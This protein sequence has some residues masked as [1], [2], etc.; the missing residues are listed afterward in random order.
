[1]KEAKVKLPSSGAEIKKEAGTDDTKGK[2]TILKKVDTT[3]QSPPGVTS[4]ASPTLTKSVF[5]D[6]IVPLYEID[7]C[8]IFGGA[9]DGKSRVAKQIAEE[10][11]ERKK[12]VLYVDTERG[13]LKR[14]LHKLGDSYR[15]ISN[16]KGVMDLV[17][18]IPSEVDVLILDSVGY[19]VLT[20]WAK[21]GVNERGNALTQ[22]IAAKD[23]IKDWAISNGKVAIVINQPD[24]DFGKAAD[25]VNRPF[26][27]KGQF[28]IK[29]V[30]LIKK[31][32][33]TPTMTKSVIE[34]YRS[35][36]DA[37]GV[38]IA[39]VEISDSGVKIS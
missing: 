26:G 37:R 36:H 38:R 30:F 35:R 20:E 12:K 22:I 23:L 34:S 6:E 17:R 27:D 21:M 32:S 13:F 2:E 7:I 5:F 19:P 11:I 18:N 33:S 15:Y 29:E 1:M 39:T 10:A 25:Y 16:L 14:D 3:I 31:V 9:G 24:S 8:E 4:P 28:V